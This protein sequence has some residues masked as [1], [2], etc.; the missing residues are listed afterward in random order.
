MSNKFFK[1]RVIHGRH[2][3]A[4]F[5]VATANLEILGEIPEIKYGVYFVDVKFG[6]QKKNGVLSFGKR[7]TFEDDF[8]VEIHILGFE[9]E[10]YGEVL[11]VEIL[12]FHRENIKFQFVELLFDQI[13]GDVLV[14]K[15]YFLRRDVFCKW[16]DTSKG[17]ISEMGQS[18]VEKISKNKDFLNAKNVLIYAPI[19]YEIPF[20]D[21]LYE[22]FPEKRYAFP[23]IVGDE[24]KFYFSK[25]SDLRSGKF[26]ILEPEERDLAEDFDLVFVPAVAVDKVKKR[27]GRGGGF[28]DRFLENVSVKTICVVPEFAVVEEISVEGHDQG[29]DEILTI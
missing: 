4:K 5:G 27:L 19:K 17:V 10:L 16:D 7:R 23:K 26:G 6:E 20:V 12:K 13:K 11:E 18:V 21:Q 3:G 8:S 15:K 24:I 29:V 28:Y 14:A 25:F 22:E 1:G 9:G 2:I